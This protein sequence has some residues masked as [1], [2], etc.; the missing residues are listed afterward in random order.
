MLKKIFYS[1]DEIIMENSGYVSFRIIDN[2]SANSNSPSCN[3]NARI[4]NPNGDHHLINDS[5]SQPNVTIYQ[6]D[7]GY[8]GF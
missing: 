4:I 6:K 2:D 1:K 8:I 7:T 5:A 3:I